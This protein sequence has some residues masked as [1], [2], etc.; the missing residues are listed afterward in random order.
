MLLID[1][2]DFNKYKE[3]SIVNSISNSLTKDSY[4]ICLFSNSL[5]ILS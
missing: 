3:V 4:E 5:I 1:L 2:T